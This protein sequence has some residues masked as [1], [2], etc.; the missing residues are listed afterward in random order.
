MPKITFAKGVE[1]Y[2]NG[3][4][5]VVDFICEKYITICINKAENKLKDVCLLVYPSQYGEITLAKE[6]NK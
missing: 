2:Y 4:Y 5:G 3:T 6:S 1:V